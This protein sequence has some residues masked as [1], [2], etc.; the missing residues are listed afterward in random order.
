MKMYITITGLKHHYGT[1]ILK[2]DMSLYL[3]KEPQSEYDKE[4]IEAYL[5]G[6]GCIGHVAN[7]VHTRVGD[8]YSAGRLYDKIGDEA[9]AKVLYIIEQSA[10]CEVLLED[11]ETKPEE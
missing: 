11:S 7:S 9:T 6:L 8:C 10:V 3:R 4:A 5:P 2:E 1:K